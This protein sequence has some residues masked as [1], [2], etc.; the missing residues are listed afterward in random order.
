MKK[1]LLIGMFLLFTAVVCAYPEDHW[2]RDASGVLVYGPRVE[3]NSISL[4]YSVLLAWHEA[5]RTKE[6]TSSVRTIGRFYDPIQLRLVKP[7]D[8]KKRWDRTGY[9][10]VNGI[11]RQA[12]VPWQPNRV[13]PG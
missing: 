8:I 1:L 3:Q 6:D 5:Q 12:I 13:V 10:S 4:P 7:L 11:E 2:V 9:T